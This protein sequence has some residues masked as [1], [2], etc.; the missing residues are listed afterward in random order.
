M[1]PGEWA[2]AGGQ[3]GYE[4]PICAMALISDGDYNRVITCG[5]EGLRGKTR[6]DVIQDIIDFIAFAQTDT[7]NAR[8]GWRYEANTAADMSVTQWPVFAM[9]AAEEAVDINPPGWVRDELL[10][11]WLSYVQDENGVFGYDSPGNPTTASSASGII[12]LIFCGVSPNDERIQKAVEA[13]ASRWDNSNIGDFYTMYSIMK[14]AMLVDPQI[15]KFGEH[16]W[17]TEYSEH[18]F[19]T[20]SADGSWPSQR[21]APDNIATAF[22]VL[23]LTPIIFPEAL[24]ISWVWIIGVAVIILA[25]IILVIAGIMRKRKLAKSKIEKPSE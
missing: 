11:S 3:T 4:T 24:P 5:D 17:R 9:M 21:H 7:G 20:Q 13:I 15:Q 16:D 8:G 18:L 23:L 19:S 25:G 10:N 2:G 12:S 22:G 1:L 14:A 6:R